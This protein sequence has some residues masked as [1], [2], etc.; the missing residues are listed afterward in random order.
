MAAGRWPAL[1]LLVALGLGAPASGADAVDKFSC[2][3]NTDGQTRLDWIADLETSRKYFEL[4]VRTRV[5]VV[6]SCSSAADL[7]AA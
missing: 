5:V 6:A 7:K 4:E 2:V 1:L 3:A